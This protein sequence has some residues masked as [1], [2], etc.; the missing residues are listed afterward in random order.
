[1]D[2]DI[3]DDLRTRLVLPSRSDAIALIRSRG[4]K[5]KYLE[6]QVIVAGGGWLIRCR[7]ADRSK[8]PLYLRTDGTIR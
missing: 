5:R 4:L 1:M 6:A 3:L 7:S 8:G 2:R